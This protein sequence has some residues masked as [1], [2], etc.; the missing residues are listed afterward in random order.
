MAWN[1]LNPDLL[2]VGYGEFDFTKQ[3]DGLVLFWSLKN[4][5][6][7]QKIYRTDC[8][9]TSL[10][11]ANKSYN[12]LAVGMYD[13]RVAVYDVR[14]EDD[15]A[16][17]E[18]SY[19]GGK[20]SDS[21]WEV[22]W[23]DKGPERAEALVSVSSDGRVTQWSMSKGLECSDLIKL[24]RVSTHK[25]VPRTLPPPHLCCRAGPPLWFHVRAPK[26][27]AEWDACARC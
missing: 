17:L 21:V 11:F 18:A 5:E 1:N 19:N 9:V 25:K 15:K 10:A 16:V 12:L 13:G 26:G 4:P 14:K 3:G 22:R 2:A 7:P 23:V 20:H 8:S 6:Y 27:R 24:K